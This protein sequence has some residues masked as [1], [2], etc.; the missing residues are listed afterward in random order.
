MSGRTANEIPKWIGMLADRRREVADTA[1][2]RLAVIG[3][4]AVDALVEALDHDLPRVRLSAVHLLGLVQD[5][6]ARASLIAMLEDRDPDVRVTSAWALARFPHPATLSALVRASTRDKAPRVRVASVEAL[7]GVFA[8][9][10]DGA[11]CPLLEMLTDVD[12]ATETRQAAMGVVPL[13]PAAQRRSICR[14]LSI[15]PDAAIRAACRKIEEDEVHDKDRKLRDIGHW[16]ERLSSDDHLEW[17]KAVRKLGR[18][19]IPAVAPLCAEMD[20]RNDP[21]FCARAGMALKAMGPRRAEAIGGALDE[22]RGALPL[23][24]LVDV[25]GALEHKPA[26]YRLR[27]L[28]V[29]LERERGDEPGEFDGPRY[30]QAKAHLELARIGSRVASPHLR[31]A[32]DTASGRLEAELLEACEM[33]GQRPEL[34]ALLRAYAR[35]DAP[36]RERITAVFRAILKRER[37]RRNS[38]CLRELPQEVQPSLRAVLPRRGPKRRKAKGKKRRTRP[39]ATAG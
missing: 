31:H 15:D 8:S 5:S 9:A 10:E 2:A 36:T 37:I 34:E 20:A 27:D 18:R 25:I 11:L 19:G 17:N 28:I 24:V 13:L 32:L 3:R 7:V 6:K 14:R 22:V 16:I 35:S 4:P 33:N 29:R 39:P 30:V 38:S 26:I 23:G 1:M 12:G 21:E